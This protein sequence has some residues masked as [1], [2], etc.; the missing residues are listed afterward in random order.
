MT[1]DFPDVIVPAGKEVVITVV[2]ADARPP[3]VEAQW[4]TT[5]PAEAHSQHL[6]ERL[7]HIRDSFQMLS[8]ARP[9]MRI[10]R[11]LTRPQLRR[12]LK[13]VDEL[14]A[15]LEDTRGVDPNHPLA[16]AYWSWINRM[17]P[18]PPYKETLSVDPAVPLW[19]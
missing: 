12:Q 4:I 19:A 2:S 1:L 6:A 7:L 3:T 16:T 5:D 15:L 13:L 10:G 8:E 18:P 11:G 17:E 14:F 9:W